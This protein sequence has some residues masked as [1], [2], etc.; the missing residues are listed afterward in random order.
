[1][2]IDPTTQVTVTWESPSQML[3]GALDYVFGGS[4]FSATTRDFFVDRYEVELYNIASNR[5]IN[6]GYFYTPQAD[7]M[8]G[9]LDHVKVR[10][11]AILRDETKAPWVESGTLTLSM[12]QA[13]FS[14]S[15]NAIFLSM[16]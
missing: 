2:A 7:L 14:E 11:R 13:D 6:Q 4:L 1:M 9:T 10:I 16:V 12:F 15:D 3:Q 8:V 5:Y